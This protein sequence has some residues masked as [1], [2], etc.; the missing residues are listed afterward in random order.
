[1]TQHERQ[2]EVECFILA[3]RL[4]MQSGAETYRAEDTLLRMAASQGYTEAES[5]V[6]PTGILFSTGHGHPIKIAQIKTRSIHLDKISRI[7]EVSRKLSSHQITVEEAYRA[8]KEIDRACYFLNQ[9]WQI[10]FSALGCGGFVIL[11]QGTFIDIPSAAIAGGLGYTTLVLFN[12]M[13]KA[14]L[15][16][17]FAAAIVVGLV[18]SFAVNTGIGLEANKI[19]IGAV[20]PLVPGVAIA[21]AVRDLMA[22]HLVSG[23]SK[24]AEACLTALAIGSGIAVSLSV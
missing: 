21:N 22:G 11:F 20:M 3:C 13:T 8:L 7:N 16:A 4:L 17:E 2:L 12:R 9:V 24:G 5:F 15:F 6:T 10:L 18:A 14:K 19:I 1:M 23:L